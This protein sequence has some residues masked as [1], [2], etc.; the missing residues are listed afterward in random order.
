MMFDLP[1]SLEV[2]GKPYA[3]RTD[4]RDILKIL[5]A[6][7]DPELQESEKRY[8]CMYILYEDFGSIPVE[9]YEDAYEQAMLFIDNGMKSEA[10][11]VKTMDWEQDAP[12]LF[13]AVNRAAGCEVR[14][15]EYLHWWTFT[16]YFME[17]RDS[18]YASVLSIRQKRAKGKK[19][20]KWESE[21]W[22]NNR[23]ICVLATRLTEEEQEEKER[24]NALLR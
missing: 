11:A 7:D 16:G 22:K 21:F 14:S 2:A 1:V 23:E 24:L 8:I 17:I 6:Y 13:P 10:N 20:E 4:F 15:L 19:L 18:I 9:A 12:I 3:I 5:T